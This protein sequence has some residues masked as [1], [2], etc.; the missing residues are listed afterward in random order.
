[1]ERGSQWFE[2]DE[3]DV[4]EYCEGSGYWKKGTSMDVLKANGNIWTPYATWQ[5]D[6]L[7]CYK[8]KFFENINKPKR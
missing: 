1:M 2:V 7:G 6:K 3:N 8:D 5:I 4:I